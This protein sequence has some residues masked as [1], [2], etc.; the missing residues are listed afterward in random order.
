MVQCAT[1]ELYSRL[2]AKRLDKYLRNIH[3]APGLRLKIIPGMLIIVP[4][5]TG[6]IIAAGV[7]RKAVQVFIALLFQISVPF[8]RRLNQFVYCIFHL[9]SSIC[10]KA[11]DFPGAYVLLLRCRNAGITPLAGRYEDHRLSIDHC[12]P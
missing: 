6:V 12:H 4:G 10:K 7:G 2:Q 5:K 1:E 11:R 8:L 3:R 9:H